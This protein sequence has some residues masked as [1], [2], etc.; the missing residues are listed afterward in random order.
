M[1][2]STQEHINQ[3]TNKQYLSYLDRY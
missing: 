3:I 2:N 1:V